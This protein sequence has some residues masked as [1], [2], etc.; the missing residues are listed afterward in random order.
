MVVAEAISYGLPVV[1]FEMPYLTFM[2]CGVIQVPKRDYKKMAFEINK[3]LRNET[4]R[5][6]T[7][8]FG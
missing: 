6:E 8:K 3:L 4:L 5:R 1:S 2:K 7:A